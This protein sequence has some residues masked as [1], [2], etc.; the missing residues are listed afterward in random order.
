MASPHWTDRREGLIERKLRDAEAKGDGLEAV[1]AQWFCWWP[2]KAVP[3]VKGESLIVADA[4]FKAE[5]LEDTTGP[6][7][8][9]V[10]DNVGHGAAVAFC[11]QVGGWAVGGRWRGV[12]EPGRRLPA[13]FNGCFGP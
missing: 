10:E 4:W 3:P 8:V 2:P 12:R 5:L 1:A 11:G 7:V 13:G 9:A 6:L